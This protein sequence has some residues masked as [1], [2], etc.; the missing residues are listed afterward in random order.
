MFGKAHKP[1]GKHTYV[2]KVQTVTNLTSAILA[3]V[4]KELKTTNSHW[5]DSVKRQ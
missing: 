5:G 3:S 2:E 1:D 4:C